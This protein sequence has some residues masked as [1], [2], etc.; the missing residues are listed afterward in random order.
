[1]SDE[2]LRASFAEYTRTGNT[3]KNITALLAYINNSPLVKDNAKIA[4]DEEQFNKVRGEITLALDK[5]STIKSSIRETEKM[6]EAQHERLNAIDEK[7]NALSAKSSE[8]ILAGRE[9]SPE[10]LQGFAFAAGAEQAKRETAKLITELENKLSQ[11][12]R[13]LAEAEYN[14]RASHERA[15]FIYSRLE[16]RK[17]FLVAGCLMTRIFSMAPSED[18]FGNIYSTEW[19]EDKFS[20]F[21]DSMRFVTCD[22]LVTDEIFKQLRDYK[23]SDYRRVSAFTKSR[24]RKPEEQKRSS[25]SVNNL[26]GLEL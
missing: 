13:E 24:E 21:L 18:Y 17:F 20:S 8:A 14:L 6:I 25:F 16:A 23:H 3:E 22:N 1:M 15:R 11:S 5:C 7:M 12:G 9:F 2:N 19:N 4:E 10:D 26:N